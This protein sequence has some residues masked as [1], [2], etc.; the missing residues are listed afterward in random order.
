MI[1][2]PMIP[3]N[4]QAILRATCFILF[5]S[6]THF[7][8]FGQEEDFNFKNAADYNNYIMKEM[9]VAVQKNFEYIS[10]NVHPPTGQASSEDF[11][12]ME[13]RRKEVTQQIVQ[14]KEKIKRMPP[15]DG[16]TRLRDEAVESLTEYQ[17][18]FELDYKDIIG[19]KKKSKDSY[20]A[21]EAYWK[22]EDKA[23]AKVNKATSRLRKAQQAYARKN[24][25]TVVEGKSDSVLD[26]KMMKI[27]AVNTYWREIY[28]PFFKI[29]KE[30]DLL[31]DI[32]SKEKVD[33]IN[34]QRSQVI[35]TVSDILPSLKAKAGFN[36]DVEFRDQ[37]IN[38]IEYYQR[39]AEKDFAKITEVLSKKPT[40]EEIDLIN[41]IINRCNADHERLV[42]N[43]NI[44]SKDLFKKNV[45]KE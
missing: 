41:S 14:S 26:Q 32:L 24:N 15:L 28:L 27:T 2:V 16:D 44:A 42:Y 22:A 25:M 40:Q 6:S 7:S 19:L 4:G 18:A 34:R 8:V 45:D 20:E 29:S 39:V 1:N 11:E 33:L 30:Y 9:V 21:M 23:E 13:T 38:L 35:K 43:W 10:F 5:I 17:H 12:L 31:W 3:F 36:G 37:T